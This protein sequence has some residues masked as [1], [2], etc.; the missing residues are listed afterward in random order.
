MKKSHVVILLVVTFILGMMAGVGGVGLAEQPIKVYINGKEM[1]S[2]QPPIIINDRVLVPLRAVSETLGA[3]VGWNYEKQTVYIATPDNP[4]N[5]EII[6]PPEFQ[7]A[8]RD[9]LQLLRDK[10]KE[11]YNFVGHYVRKIVMFDRNYSAP[12]ILDMGV[13]IQSNY[14]P[15]P[16]WWAATIVHEAQHIKQHYS[17]IFITTDEDETVAYNRGIYV[18]KKTGAPQHT[19]DYMQ[20]LLDSKDWQN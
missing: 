3:S 2:D 10:D 1:V 11:N 5:I 8:M 12:G 16:Y 19:I 17:G 9:A 14:K 4:E 20:K 7:K 13:Y 6:G 15:D 18:L